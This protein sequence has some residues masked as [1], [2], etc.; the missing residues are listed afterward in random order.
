MILRVPPTNLLTSITRV[1]TGFLNTVN[2]PS[3]GLTTTPAGTGA[4]QY[5]MLGNVVRLNMEL[6]GRAGK[7][8]TLYAGDYM[9]VKVASTA[10]ASGIRG[11][12]AFWDI[13]ANTGMQNYQ[14]TGDVATTS[15]Y[16]AGVFLNTVTKGYYCWIQISGLASVLNAASLV[17]AALGNLAFIEVALTGAVG[18]A[19][20]NALASATAAQ[21]ASVFGIA[22]ELPVAGA[23]KLV[24]LY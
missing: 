22:Y 6:A 12:L 11:R 10:T 15:E 14:V 20:F 21:Q 16:L 3:Q 19:D 23:V 4:A 9:Y 7:T 2:D 24:A 18:A 1:S 5:S 17:N 8:Y 13:N